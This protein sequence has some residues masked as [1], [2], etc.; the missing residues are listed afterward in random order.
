[1]RQSQRVRTSKAP[2]TKAVAEDG[3]L[4]RRVLAASEALLESEGL[5]ALSL[6]EVARRAGVSHQA[7][8]HHFPDR[9]SI[10]AA[11][12]A[13]GFDDLTGRLDAAI[14]GADSADPKKALISAGEA[15]VRFA[16]D[17]PGVFRVMFRPEIVDVRRF[18]DAEQA[19]ARAFAQLE[20]LVSLLR[21]TAERK[22]LTSLQW[23]TVHGLAC[24]LLDGSLGA[25]MPER[26]DRAV[27]VREVM[28][29]FAEA[30]VGAVVKTPARPRAT[31]Q[32]R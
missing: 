17:R 21:S 4:R 14:S 30:M 7:P 13:Q 1:M 27:H 20:R 9:E 24:L 26:R 15:Y 10:L 25:A 32:H 16:L 11:L 23:A 22:V 18:A 2:N 29:R 28:E 19:G 5:A 12:V 31:K 3:D 6:R 8:Y